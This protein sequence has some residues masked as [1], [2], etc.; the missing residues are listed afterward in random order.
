MLQ[1][2][3][4]VVL[5]VAGIAGCIGCSTSSHYLYATIPAANELAAYRED[6][7]SGTLTQLAG[8]PYTVGDEDTSVVLHPSNKYLYVVNPGQGEDDISLFD[9]GSNGTFTEVPPRTPEGSGAWRT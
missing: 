4:V 6:P 2:V 1:K 3:L 8:S 7:Y 9:I 5:V